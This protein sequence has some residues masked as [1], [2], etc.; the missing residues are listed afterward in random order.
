MYRA[1]TLFRG[2]SGNSSFAGW[3]LN[4]NGAAVTTSIRNYNS[5]VGSEPFLNGSSG[6]YV[7]DMYNAW[8]ADPSSVHAVSR[9]FFYLCLF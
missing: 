9:P 6:Q 4:K 3:L 5:P 2:I 1:R 8:L 7:E